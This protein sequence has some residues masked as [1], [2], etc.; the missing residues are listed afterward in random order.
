MLI[1]S[2][3]PDASDILDNKSG[4]SKCLSVPLMKKEVTST[5]DPSD[6]T[7]LCSISSIKHDTLGFV[8]FFILHLI[9]LF[10]KLMFLSIDRRIGNSFKLVLQ[11]KQKPSAI[12]AKNNY[13]D[14]EQDN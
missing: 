3:G 2:L 1:R 13:P 11:I 14:K 5:T 10:S 9:S 12:K 6:T 8:S 7:S 4:S